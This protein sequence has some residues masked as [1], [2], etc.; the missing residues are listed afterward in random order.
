MLSKIRTAFALGGQ[1]WIKDSDGQS[2]I[3]CPRTCLRCVDSGECQVMF[4]GLAA[5]FRA[6][7][8]EYRSHPGLSTPLLRSPVSP[9]H[10]YPS[11]RAKRK[12]MRKR[13]QHPTGGDFSLHS[14]YS[15]TNRTAG[16]KA[17][18]RL[19][20][21]LVLQWLGFGCGRLKETSLALT[22]GQ[23]LGLR[24]GLPSTLDLRFRSA[25][26]RSSRATTF[27]EYRLGRNPATQSRRIFNSFATAASTTLPGR[28]C[29]TSKPAAVPQP[30][31][32]LFAAEFK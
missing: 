16:K 1:F 24:S 28:R 2:H 13:K 23:T 22:R 19:A 29:E 10:P 26:A 9:S 18:K 4:T 25:P 6:T 27:L 30:N 15:Q 3:M 12:I 31:I 11:G 21:V 32:R 8:Q 5:V 20:S 7:V 17:A 14:T